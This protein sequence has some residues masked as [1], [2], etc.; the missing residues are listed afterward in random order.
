[1]NRERIQLWVDALRSGDYTQGTGALEF[2]AFSND[3][4]EIGK[5]H[6]C[7]GVACRVA[8]NNGLK[9]EVYDNAGTST[10]ACNDGPNSSMTSGHMPEQVAEWFGFPMLTETSTDVILEDGVVATTANDKLW[11]SFDQI[12][13]ALESRYLS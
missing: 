6:C 8:I 9:V 5:K 3:G 13:D 2:R 10:F 11:W 4:E 12:A 7:L 1:M